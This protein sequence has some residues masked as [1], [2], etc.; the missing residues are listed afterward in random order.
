[1]AATIMIVDD[2]PT[3]LLSIEGILTKAGLTVVKA[4]SGEKALDTLKS[5][6]K[7]NLLITDLNMGE[8]NG[9]DLIRKVRKLPGFAF[10]PILMLTTESQQDKRNEAKSAGATGWI[11]KPVDSDGLLGVI[12]QLVPGA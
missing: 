10:L 8:M 1:M 6:T 9:I 5:G 11:V 3:M 12:R 4:P 2:S 7:P